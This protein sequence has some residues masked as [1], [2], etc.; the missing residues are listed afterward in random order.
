GKNDYRD[1][2]SEA[3]RL[4][5]SSQRVAQSQLPL[6]LDQGQ[7]IGIGERLLLD[8]W[9]M[10]ET[11]GFALPP[12][13]LALEPADE[14]VLQTNGRTR[15]LRLT[16]IDD[17]PSRQMQSV[18]TDPSIYERLVGPARIGTASSGTNVVQTGRAS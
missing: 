18:A 14:V 9:V 6:V 16:Q 17:G 10:R 3:R 12:A 4:V 15:R 5:G 2:V 1:A 11:V 7:A 13:R 8:A